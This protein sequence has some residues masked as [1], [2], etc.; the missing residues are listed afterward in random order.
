MPSDVPSENTL[1]SGASSHWICWAVQAREGSTG[2]VESMHCVTVRARMLGL[3][4]CHREQASWVCL[5]QK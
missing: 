5:L 4:G 3:L 2:E 1:L